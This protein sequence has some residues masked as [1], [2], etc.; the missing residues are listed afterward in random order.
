MS[1]GLRSE[2]KELK[3]QQE[4]RDN[5]VSKHSSRYKNVLWLL[6]RVKD[7]SRIIRVYLTVVAPNAVVLAVYIASQA[8]FGEDVNL[9][10]FGYFLFLL[11]LIPRPA[12]ILECRVPC[13]K[14]TIALWVPLL[15]YASV[16]YVAQY[17]WQLQIFAR[18]RAE[19]GKLD[20]VSGWATLMGLRDLHLADVITTDI[21]ESTT[22]DFSQ[23]AIQVHVMVITC[24]CMARSLAS[25]SLYRERFE[26]IFTGR[27]TT[28]DIHKRVKLTI[29]NR[30]QHSIFVA[31]EPTDI[32]KRG[33]WYLLRITLV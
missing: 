26:D 6:A 21:D 23:S 8:G 12:R 27:F 2:R 7:A 20:T 22:S 11:V 33:G 16:A 17:S 1:I 32:N 4:K 24:I 3:E 13:C 14:Q 25:A 18:E 10:S 28:S 5:L 29:H 31:A 15:A 19:H 30:T 9:I